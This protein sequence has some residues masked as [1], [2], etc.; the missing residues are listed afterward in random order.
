[1]AVVQISKIQ[2]RRGQKNSQSGI[3]QLSSAEMA[4]AVDTQ[5]LF[6]GNGS[7]AEGAPFVGNTKILTER[8][9][10]LELASSYEFA[11][12]DPSIRNTQSRTL[13]SKLDESVSI[14]DF[15]AVGDGITDNV[16]AFETAFNQLFNN[17]DNR[18][19]KVLIIPNGTYVFK[20]ALRIPSN[21]I[22]R[23][24]TSRGSILK[25]DNN[26]IRFVTSTGEELSDFNSMNRP[27][28]VNI[29][30]LTILR[31]SGQVVLSGV[32]KSIFSNINFQGNY[33]LGESVSSL[34]A[35]PSAVFWQNLND[36]I[37]TTDITF[38]FCN[39]ETSSI[40]VKCTTVDNPLSTKIKFNKCNFFVNHIGVLIFGVENQDNDWIINDCEF[41][42]IVTQALRAEAGKNTKLLNCNF[43]KVGNGTGLA[44][45]P[46]TPM[47]YFEEKQGNILIDCSSDRQQLA[48]I[49]MQSNIPAISEVVNSDKAVFVNRNF[50][51]VGLSDTFTPIAVFSA[52]NKYY[53]INYFLQLGIYS[54][55]GKLTMTVSN[56]LSNVSIT[57]HYQYSP[58]LVNDPGG[59]LMTN[60]EFDAEVRNNNGFDT[61]I[62]L[63]KNP[64]GADQAEGLMSFD[65][66]YGV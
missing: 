45:N 20:S 57:D 23:G 32:S 12:D 4:W 63:Y 7:V 8:D 17:V 13:Q 33:I 46:E 60:F 11:S 19:K 56:D 3:P 18:Y 50:S 37:S 21:V 24:E 6:I 52:D 53:T 55:S 58:S 59:Q 48:G 28:L 31:S 5:E 66:T 15:G 34:I 41:E 38:E 36:G 47:I 30:N 1:M 14:L 54:R 26:D 40:G 2:L 10:L 61:I 29:S 16:A 22:M 64:L 43:K 25:I 27:V 35:E 9:N 65:V 51:N 39:F 44:T 62:L 42:E 49:V